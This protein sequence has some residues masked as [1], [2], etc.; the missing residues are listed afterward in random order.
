MTPESEDDN[1]QE[2]QKDILAGR[3]FSIADVIGREGASFLKG[4]SPIPRLI[5]AQNQINV[6]IRDYLADTSG[7]VQA[8]LFS[9]VKSDDTRVSRNLENPKAALQEIVES[10]TNDPDTL[11]EFV[12]QIDCK[13]GEMN[14]ERPHFQRPGQPPHPDDEFTHESVHTQLQAL[15]TALKSQT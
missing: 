1:N 2:L 11:Y 15:L 7:I 8:I 10:I 3:T 9:W 4:E 5:Q 6:Y 14:N 13:W 12:R